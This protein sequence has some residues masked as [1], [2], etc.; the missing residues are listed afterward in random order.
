MNPESLNMVQDWWLPRFHRV[1]SSEG[2]RR[3][4]SCSFDLSVPANLARYT[5]QILSYG[6]VSHKSFAHALSKVY[7]AKTGKEIN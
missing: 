7:A 5:R 6:S 3:F 1:D 2:Q 4:M